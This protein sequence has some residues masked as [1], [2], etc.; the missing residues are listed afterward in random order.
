MQTGFSVQPQMPEQ[1]PFRR[2]PAGIAVISLAALLIMGFVGFAVLTGYYFFKIQSGDGA[3]IAEQFIGGFSRDAS[4]AGSGKQ[5]TD[6]AVRATI[7]KHSP[8]IGPE[9]A[10]ITVVAFIDFECPFCQRSHPIFSKVTDEFGSAVRVVFKHFPLSTIHPRSTPA[11][12]AAG[13]A[14]TQG[15]F[16][17]YYNHLFETNQLSDDS[18]SSA[19]KAVGLNEATFERCSAAQLP[20]LNINQD[21]QDGVALGVQG[22]P[23]YFVNGK[24]LEGVLTEEQW[25]T[26]FLSEL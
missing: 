20:V 7:R 13:C 16:W 18:L 3:E 11:T 5:V 19:A 1:K 25:R 6:V 9:K 2:T 4:L 14:H 21:L 23:T 8:A 10:P 15:K 24:K 26:I 22:T 17:P 12:I